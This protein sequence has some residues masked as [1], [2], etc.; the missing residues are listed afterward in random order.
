MRGGIDKGGYE[1]Q[2]GS[3]TS[4]VTQGDSKNLFRTK[5]EETQ[6]NDNNT[7]YDTHI[8]LIKNKATTI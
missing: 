3:T 1:N 5:E 2:W 6:I 7:Y 8:N 4:E